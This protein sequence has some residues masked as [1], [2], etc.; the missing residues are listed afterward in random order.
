MSGIMKLDRASKCMETS[1]LELLLFF[2][3]CNKFSPLINVVTQSK[4]AWQ[5]TE[6]PADTNFTEGGSCALRY[7]RDILLPNL[8]PSMRW[9]DSAHKIL[10]FHLFK[11]TINC[12]FHSFN[13][14]LLHAQYT[15][16]T[17]VTLDLER[18]NLSKNDL[19]SNRL[20]INIPGP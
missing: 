7:I 5:E 1:N 11:A 14:Y 17:A 8:G 12:E 2:C 3:C 19:N 10:A 13:K 15:P 18:S 16:G 9:M 6:G 20:Y 4:C